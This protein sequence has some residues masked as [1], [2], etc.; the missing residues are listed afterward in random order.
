MSTEDDP[1]EDDE[2][3]SKEDLEGFF[4][5]REKAEMFVAVGV[6]IRGD[7][8][9]VF[10]VLA[11]EDEGEEKEGVV[12]APSDKGPVGAMP[13]A[14]E[15]EDDESVADYFS[16]RDARAA[17]RDINVVPEPCSEGYMPATPEFC[18][19]TREIGVV[20]V[21][22]QFDTKQFGCAD[23]NV[24][25][26]G[27]IAVDLECEKDGGEEE[28]RACLGVV[29]RPHLVHVGSAVVGYYYFLE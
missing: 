15:E 19:V 21:A 20:E 16:F 26:A 8:V 4:Q 12:G 11:E 1:A 24:R 13:E 22:H 7:L 14:G 23:G 28:C 18:D 9:G 17:E 25:I 10:A 3:E 27:E 5:R 29:S 6:G 2:G